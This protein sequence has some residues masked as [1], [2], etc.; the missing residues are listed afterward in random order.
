[1]AF[2]IPNVSVI[3]PTYNRPDLLERAVLSVLGQTL[4]DVEIV[5]VN[6]AGQPVEDLLHR[7]DAGRGQILSIRAARNCGRGAVR[8]LGLK[9]ASGR[10][11]AYLDDDDYYYPE[12]LKVL[13]DFLESSG[14]KVAYTDSLNAVQQQREGRW[15][16]LETHLHYSYDFDYD[17][18]FVNNFIPTLC[19]MHARECLEKSGLFDETLQTQEDWDM[20]LRISLYYTFHHIKQVTSEYTTRLGAVSQ[21]RTD[22]KADFYDTLCR[23]YDKYANYVTDKPEVRAKQEQ[24]RRGTRDAYEKAQGQRVGEFVQGIMERLEAQD[25]HAAMVYYNQFRSALQFEHFADELAR[26]DSL[27]ERVGRS[28]NGGTNKG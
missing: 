26:I 15:E 3:I 13:F 25:P 18:I 17:H 28:V 11:I 19:I 27:M 8:N 16:T 6:D 24:A 7:L 9:L 10:Y 4:P 5:V 22:P 2:Y 21:S 12:H 14:E 20:W 23:I 1:M